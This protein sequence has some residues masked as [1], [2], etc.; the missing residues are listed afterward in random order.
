MLLNRLR[1]CF[2]SPAGSERPF[3]VGT[4]ETAAAQ[5]YFEVNG[6]RL[7]QLTGH[8]ALLMAPFAVNKGA[9]GYAQQVERMKAH[10][11]AGGM[12]GSILH[13]PNFATGGDN[14]DRD[15]SDTSA[16]TSCLSPGGANLA[17]YRAWLDNIADFWNNDC[18]VVIDGK[19]VKIPLLIRTGGEA[20]GWYDYPD[21]TV[22]SLTRAG[23]TATMV[24]V[25]GGNPMASAWTVGQR[26]Q[27]RGASDVKWNRMHRATGVTIDP[28]GNGG[29][30]TFTITTG[31]ASN[32]GGTIT[33]YPAAG[34]WWAGADRA[35]DFN[36]LVRQTIDYM[37]DV[38]GCNQV[39]WGSNLF[40]W[41]RITL[42]SD[43][44]TN[45]YSL[46]HTGMS[47]YFDFVSIDL[48]QDEDPDH[49]PYIDFGHSDIVTKFK[50]FVDW[51]DTYGRPIFVYEFGGLVAGKKMSNFWS[52]LCMGAFDKKFPRIAGAVFWSPAFLPDD[53]T[54][55]CD[56]F[57]RAMAN[58]RYRYLT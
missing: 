45:A 44:A 54:P 14:F 48:Y 38:K 2:G 32:P 17:A 26:F 35:S 43:P 6:N 18:V 50:P 8:K 41:N 51:C 23:T 31:P 37:R 34:S 52:E 47:N 29:T 19:T 39:L 53:N 25:R 3:F 11:L 7:E 30:V 24:F 20:N 16:V 12:C 27:I 28:D 1:N 4:N 15:K 5:P 22:T 9:Q 13:P 21:M 10:Y 56:D 55:A 49:W 57:K 46:W 33:T 42:S 40:T 36:L 58:P